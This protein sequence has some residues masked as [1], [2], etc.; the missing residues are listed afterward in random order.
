VA[1]HHFSLV[2]EREGEK[3]KRSGARWS[4]ETKKKGCDQ[5]LNARGQVTR[6]E[7]LLDI[8]K[9]LGSLNQNPFYADLQN[10][11]LPM[12]ESLPKSFT[13]KIFEQNFTRSRPRSGI[14]ERERERD[15]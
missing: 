3:K 14:K 1:K 5:Y 6:Y 9:N 15:M 4:K 10:S 13:S 11:S 2:P 8:W 7:W 12:I